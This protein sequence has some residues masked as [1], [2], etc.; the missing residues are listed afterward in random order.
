MKYKRLRLMAFRI[1]ELKYAVISLLLFI[2]VSS[3]SN[4]FGQYPTNDLLGRFKNAARISKKLEKMFPNNNILAEL[5][6]GKSINFPDI[7]SF[8]PGFDNLFN[9]A[10]KTLKG[11]I[12]H[13]A[14]EYLRV[15]YPTLLELNRTIELTGDKMKSSV[16]EIVQYT[17]SQ[18][19]EERER[20]MNDMKSLS[21]DINSLTKERID[22]V[23]KGFRTSMFAIIH[24]AEREF[25]NMYKDIVEYTIIKLIKAASIIVCL[26]LIAIAAQRVT[27]NRIRLYK[28]LPVTL[29]FVGLIIYIFCISNVPFHL[30]MKPEPDQVER[31]IKYWNELQKNMKTGFLDSSLKSAIDAK[32]SLL[33]SGYLW[34]WRIGHGKDRFCVK[35]RIEKLDSIIEILYTL[36]TGG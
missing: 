11:V 30:L 19:S 10:D 28:E 36:Q 32:A 31:E 27:S 21:G 15:L 35:D 34:S 6:Q 14:D 1:W 20:I 25:A 13:A 17:I 23:F 9:N 33:S 7:E 29:V 3:T 12:T 4:S 26:I 8:L 5:P 16:K 22:Q 18:L 24:K 2:I